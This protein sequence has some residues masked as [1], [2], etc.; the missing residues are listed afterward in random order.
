MP[1]FELG[2]R[3]QV[4]QGLQGSLKKVLKE[5]VMETATLPNVP[6]TYTSR[7]PD[8]SGSAQ[9]ISAELLPMPRLNMAKVFDSHA[10]TRQARLQDKLG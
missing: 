3:V 1:Q 8:S 5:S 4:S 6:R 7:R 2:A 9:L 10:A